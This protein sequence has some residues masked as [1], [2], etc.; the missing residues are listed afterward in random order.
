MPWCPSSPLAL[1]AC[2]RNVSGCALLQELDLRENGLAAAAA[3]ELA[4]FL[5]SLRHLHSLDLS[6]N[7]VTADAA[8]PLAAAVAALTA[9][10]ELRL[11]HAALASGSAAGLGELATALAAMPA[12]RLLDLSKNQ[13]PAANVLDVLT[14]VAPAPALEELC[15]GGNRMPP[16]ALRALAAALPPGAP[17]RVLHAD[18][19]GI[20]DETE[21]GEAAPA[22]PDTLRVLHLHNSPALVND[23]TFVEFPLLSLRQDNLTALTALDVSG[24]VISDA[25]LCNVLRRTRD[26]AA[27]DVS[28]CKSS[29]PH[30]GELA[31]A[32]GSLARL[33]R[34]DAA[35]AFRGVYGPWLPHLTACPALA[36]LNLSARGEHGASLAALPAL[37]HLNLA[38]SQ[39][40]RAGVDALANSL[41]GAAALAHLDVA[42]CGVQPAALAHLLLM[43]AELPLEC[44][45]ISGAG[46]PTRRRQALDGDVV[47]ASLATCTRLR[48]LTWHAAPPL[49]LARLGLQLTA[50]TRLRDVDLQG[51]Q[52]SA[53][54]QSWSISWLGL[55]AGS[56]T[57]LNLK[58][59]RLYGSGDP[60]YAAVLDE[61]LRTDLLPTLAALTRLEALVLSGND[62]AALTD[63]HG[64][65][66]ADALGGLRRLRVLKLRG[67]ALS[68]ATFAAVAQRA[69]R[70]LLHLQTLDLAGCPAAG[71]AEMKVLD[72]SLR[73]VLGLS[74]LL[75][76]HGGKAC[77]RR[78][79]EDEHSIVRVALGR[80]ECKT[81][82]CADKGRAAGGARRVNA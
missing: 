16:R 67:L 37:T 25:A 48:A 74:W 73:G 53:S 21:D 63:A 28:R 68:A 31:D 45:D 8:A 47:G 35:R 30:T 12:L 7:P 58:N 61:L 3:A 22:L 32:V 60:A 52:L 46:A 80:C 11:R 39:L 6:H 10:R 9:L 77:A 13:L 71:T 79:A 5:P 18:G 70:R 49:V 57:S 75:L 56:L 15:I 14:R 43:A 19:G 82:D 50:L 1:L 54:L 69:V 2:S 78:V 33:T 72:E 41:P 4:E 36:H 44:L 62:A 66:L 26:L 40:Q 76:D 38:R 65:L 64:E 17:L 27:L 59:T 24:N 34:L 55:L 81:C 51:T 20:A 23:G 29:T 42:A